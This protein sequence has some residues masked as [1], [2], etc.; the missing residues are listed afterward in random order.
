MSSKS[1]FIILSYTVSSVGE[2]FETLIYPRP[3]IPLK[4]FLCWY[5]VTSIFAVFVAK[6]YKFE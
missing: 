5:V 1:I 6:F 3:S 2:F 4:Q